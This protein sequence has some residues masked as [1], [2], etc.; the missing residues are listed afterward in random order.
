M[1]AAAN[2]YALGAPANATAGTAFTI[3]ADRARPLRQ[4]CDRLYRHRL[5]HERRR[6]RAARVP[7]DYTFVARRLRCPYVHEWGHFCSQAGDLT[8]TATDTAT[9]ITGQAAT[10]AVAC[11]GHVP[12]LSQARSH[13][14]RDSPSRHA[15]GSRPVSG[16]LHRVTR[17]GPLHRRRQQPGDASPPI[18]LRRRRQRRAPFTRMSSVRQAGDDDDRDGHGHGLDHGDEQHDRRSEPASATISAPSSGAR[19]ATGGPNS[20]SPSPRSILMATTL[21]RVIGDG[22]FTK[23][24]SGALSVVPARL[25]VRRGRRGR[26]HV[27]QRRDVRHVRQRH[28]H[29]DRHELRVTGNASVNVSPASATHYTL[30]APAS[31]TAGSPFTITLTAFD[32]FNNIATGYTGTAH[33]TKSDGGLGSSVPAN[34]TFVA[35]DAGTHTFTNGVTFVSAGSTRSRRPIRATRRSRLRRRCSSMQRPRAITRSSALV[36]RRRAMRSRS[37]S[38]RSIRST[39]SPRAISARLT[40]RRPTAASGTRFRGITPSPSATRGCTRSRME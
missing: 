32:A 15:H 31:A 25:R 35:G 27:H 22:H 10:I 19:S 8:V 17:D 37:R 3:H 6:A 33:F 28:G 4:H 36:R 11:D 40:S 1:T 30:G 29:G 12:S 18:T 5:L 7:A 34:Y 26:A 24:D 13:R 20:P 16:T 23:S 38:R 21:P 39:T 2:H 14:P 9:V